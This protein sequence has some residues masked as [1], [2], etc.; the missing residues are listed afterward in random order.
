MLH[1]TLSRDIA[2]QNLALVRL[3]LVLAVSKLTSLKT[4]QLLVRKSF[5]LFQGWLRVSKASITRIAR[6]LFY[7]I[8][9]ERQHIRADLIRALIMLHGRFDLTLEE[10][11]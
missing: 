5:F 3:I 11:E 6:D 7:I 2:S 9:I 8:R 10:A 1:G 4:I